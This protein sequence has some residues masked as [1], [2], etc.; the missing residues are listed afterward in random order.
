MVAVAFMKT[1]NGRVLD[2][3]DLKGGTATAGWWRALYRADD[4]RLEVMA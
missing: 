1:D 2:A 3:F 4:I